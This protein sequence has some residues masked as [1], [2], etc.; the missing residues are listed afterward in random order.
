[1]SS[2]KADWK[3]YQK[4]KTMREPFIDQGIWFMLLRDAKEYSEGSGFENI[5]TE[6]ITQL[7]PTNVFAS[8]FD[9][10]PN[11]EDFK[12]KFVEIPAK[13]YFSKNYF[14]M[15]RFSKSQTKINSLDDFNSYFSCRV[16]SKVLNAETRIV[17]KTCIK[18]NLNCCEDCFE[19]LAEN[20]KCPKGC[21][22]NASIDLPIFT[23]TSF[24]NLLFKCT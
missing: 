12:T 22:E 16:C 7:K 5:L 23:F 20:K 10:E 18:C 9:F 4:G 24:Q 13:D 8:S 14:K 3:P 2:E 1:M 19:K 6:F 11:L 21:L 15:M 17:N